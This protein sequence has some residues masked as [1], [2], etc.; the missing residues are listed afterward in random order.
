MKRPGRTKALV[1]GALAL[2]LLVGGAVLLEHQRQGR[3]SRDTPAELAELRL[4][5]A[6]LHSRLQ[7]LAARDPLVKEALQKDGDVL[8]AVRSRFL[9]DVLKE[10]ARRYLDTV[11][12]DLGEIRAQA[13]GVVK[14]DTFL[15][16]IEAGDWAVE[17]RIAEMR[18]VLKASA[19]TLD[20][21]ENV[22]TVGI[23]VSLQE[24][25]G[26]ARL[27]FAWDSK[28]LVNVVCRDFELEQE[29]V[30]RALSDRY[31]IEGAFV[32]SVEPGKLAATPRFPERRYPIRLDLTP[33]SW[34]SVESALRSQDSLFKCGIGIDREKVMDRL[35]ELAARGIE[36]E[37]PDKLFRTVRSPSGIQR[38][39][40]V[41]GRRIEL[42]VKTQALSVSSETFWS[43]AAVDAV[44]GRPTKGAPAAKAAAGAPP[45]A[46]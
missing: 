41:D 36:V 40:D 45:A 1:A 32:L 20:V 30:G 23:P 37:L 7:G 35:R 11:V 26:T 39:V 10:A 3:A 43:S 31:S 14:K 9:G 13:Q 42:S 15:G 19:P 24:T 46:Q 38:S 21:A 29:L 25:T 33:E 4:L 2:V 28:A 22:V 18:G 17:V 5:D 8:L 34:A 6:Q 12:L 44:A 27:R 16:T